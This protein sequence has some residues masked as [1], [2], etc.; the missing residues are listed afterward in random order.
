MADAGSGGEA[1]QEGGIFANSTAD[2]IRR[3][4]YVIEG[5]CR[6]VRYMWAYSPQSHR[7]STVL[8]DSGGRD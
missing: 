4:Y 7:L 2:G 3:A 1:A 8:L 5:P 6:A